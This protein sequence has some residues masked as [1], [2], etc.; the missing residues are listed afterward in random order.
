MAKQGKDEKTQDEF[1]EN[2]VDL[3]TVTVVGTNEFEELKQSGYPISIIDPEKFAARGMTGTELLE[4]VPGVR[5]KRA[6][7]L[8]SATRISIRGLEGKRV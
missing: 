2:E 7:G 8:G 3:D 4:R 6:G 5:V 1:D